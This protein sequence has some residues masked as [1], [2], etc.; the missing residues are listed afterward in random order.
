MVEREHI[1]CVDDNRFGREE[2][3]FDNVC[4]SLVVSRRFA[5]CDP[6]QR[7]DMHVLSNWSGHAAEETTERRIPINS[8]I[9]GLFSAYSSWSGNESS[10]LVG[11]GCVRGAL[12]KRSRRRR[13]CV[14]GARCFGG[15]GDFGSAVGVCCAGS[16]CIWQ[17]NKFEGRGIEPVQKA[18]VGRGRGCAA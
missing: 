14:Y 17:E 8:Q 12:S 6:V 10:F 3:F 2:N 15:H 11:R 18:F 4:V 13:V 1:F 5:R 16:A 9:H 7:L